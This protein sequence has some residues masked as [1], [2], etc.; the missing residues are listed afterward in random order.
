MRFD[1]KGWAMPD[2][3]DALMAYDLGCTD[4]GISDPEMKQAIAEY[5]RSL[6]DSEFNR[7]MSVL[8][9]DHYLTD[10]AIEAGYGIED[11]KAVLEWLE[12]LSIGV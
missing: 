7:E 10:A 8:I 6:S 1:Y 5:L 4:S 12:G 9:R 3:I 11:A 2:A